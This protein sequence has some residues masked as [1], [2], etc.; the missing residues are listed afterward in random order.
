ML[1]DLAFII[2]NIKPEA[3]QSKARE[4]VMMMNAVD[5]DDVCAN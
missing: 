3:L 5:V 1:Y 2:I 4:M